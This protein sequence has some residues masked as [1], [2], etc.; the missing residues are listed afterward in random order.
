[1]V[2]APAVRVFFPNGLSLSTVSSKY[3]FSRKRSMSVIRLFSTVIRKK[4]DFNACHGSG[5]RV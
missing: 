3:R 1:L 2:L 4:L 5:L